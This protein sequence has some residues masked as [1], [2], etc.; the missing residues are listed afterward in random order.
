MPY[1]FTMSMVNYDPGV[2]NSEAVPT[3]P[4]TAAR[5]NLTSIMNQ[6]VH[7][8]QLVRISRREE[9]MILVDRKELNQLLAN[10]QFHPKVRFSEGEVSIRLP[11]LGLISSGETYTEAVDDL[12]TLMIEYSAQFMARLDFYEHTEKVVHVPF[13]LRIALSDTEAL[14]N[15]LVEEQS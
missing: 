3:I 5:K 1:A 2:E 9:E 14:R 15:L 8:R 13:C 12:L 7:D 11:E 10:F 6:V 4:F